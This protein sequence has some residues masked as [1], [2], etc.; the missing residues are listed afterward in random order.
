M[1]CLFFLACLPPIGY[2][3]AHDTELKAEELAG[4]GWVLQGAGGRD[5]SQEGRTT[6]VFGKENKL[7]GRAACN[8]YFGG[9]EL[10]KGSFSVG[11]IGATKMFCGPPL[12]DLEEAYL[13]ALGNAQRVEKQDD[14]L[15]MH[16]EG[17]EAPLAFVPFEP[18]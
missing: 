15:L 1:L 5:A 8:G 3:C 18:E 14:R 12:M 17:L 9:F 4:T 11:P 13:R 2:G 10:E 7:S 6:L 16:C